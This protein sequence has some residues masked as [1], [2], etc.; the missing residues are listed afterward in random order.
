MKI[1]WTHIFGFALLAILWG[2]SFLAIR[3]SIDNFPPFAAASLRVATA[4]ALMFFYMR[5]Q[6]A[7][8]PKDASLVW[9]LLGV[10]FFTLGLPWAL[11]FWGERFVSPAM[12]S[13]LNS[14]TPL[15]VVIVAALFTSQESV[16]WNKWL[17]VAVG[18]AGVIV[19]FG[20]KIVLGQGQS[21]FGMLA[22]VGMAVCYA[23]GI[24]W[25]KSL[26]HKTSASVAFF[27]QGVGALLF[28]LP[29]S[30]LSEWSAMHQSNWSSINGWVAVMYL[31]V[32]STAIA[33][34]IFFVLLRELGSVKASAVTYFIPIVAVILDW[35]VFGKF[36]SISSLV[37][38]VVVLVGVR[39]IH[40]RTPDVST[41]APEEAIPAV[42]SED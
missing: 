32:F 13:I 2:G 38:A 42:A 20:P 26:A 34:L 33:Q 19:I 3:F 11:L 8:L 6:K 18:F 4:T 9:Q 30:F 31:G 15:F 24:V 39:L 12:G 5:L 14:T 41:F 40:M 37:G 22:I 29:L 25:L 1:K 35:L 16:R 17:G 36:L 23:I 28:L 27:L 7:A 10:G 21:F